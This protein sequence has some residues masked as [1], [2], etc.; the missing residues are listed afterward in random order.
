M[1]DLTAVSL[2]LA[3]HAP[4]PLL[5]LL[6]ALPRPQHLL[7]PRQLLQ[8]TLLPPLLAILQVKVGLS[9]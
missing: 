8:Q 3:Q 5:L 2:L 9:A 4:G 6:S 1:Q 7:L